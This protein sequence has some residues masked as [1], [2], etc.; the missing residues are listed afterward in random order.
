MRNR[1]HDRQ[2]KPQVAS[3]LEP[4]GSS[5]PSAPSGTGARRAHNRWPQTAPPHQAPHLTGRFTTFTADH[6]RLFQRRLQEH[7]HLV[8]HFATRLVQCYPEL[9]PLLAAVAAHDQTKLDPPTHHGF[10]LDL[11][12]PTTQRTPAIRT[13]IEEAREHHRRAQRHHPEHWHPLALMPD[14]DL[15]EMVADWAAQ[16]IRTST[17]LRPFI[18]SPTVQDWPWSATQRRRID[19]LASATGLNAAV[20]L[21]PPPQLPDDPD[22]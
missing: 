13:R 16:A 22:D 5:G 11:L 2:P 9:G 15:A 14:L 19:A 18:E 1:Q 3:L 6:E 21:P 8:Y 4:S 17:P 7:Q 10:L 20:K 12:V